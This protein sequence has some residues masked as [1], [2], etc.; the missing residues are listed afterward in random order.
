MASFKY[1]T[2]VLIVTYGLIKL[3][4]V[5][6]IFQQNRYELRRLKNWLIDQ[7]KNS[8]SLFSGPLLLLVS[9]LILK[10]WFNSFSYLV[11]SL[12]L[13][14][15][16]YLAWQKDQKRHYIIPLKITARVKRQITVYL[17]LLV[18]ISFLFY[19]YDG[20]IYLAGLINWLPWFLMGLTGLLTWPLEKLFHILYQQKAVSILRNR[21]NLIKIG[22]TGSYGKTSTKNIVTEILS[23]KYYCLMTPAS[24]NTP[25][26]ITMTIRQQLTALHQIFV[27]EMGADKVGEIKQL[28]R[29]VEPQYGIVTS[30]GYQHLVTFKTLNNIIKEKMSLI[31]SLPATGVGILNR[32]NAYIAS[33]KLKNE[34]QIK[35]FG[36]NNP[37]VDYQATEI[38]YALTGSQFIVK[39]KTEGNFPFQSPLLGEHNVA[40]VLA[41]IALGRE[42]GLTWSVLQLAVSRLKQVKNRLELK[43]INNFTFIDNS[44]NSNPASAKESLRIL[45]Q[46]PARKF[47]IT[48]G[49]IDLGVRQAEENYHFGEQMLNQVDEVILVGEKQ[50][51]DIYAGLKASGFPLA[52]VR[53][54]PSTAEAFQVVF[55]QAQVEDIILIEND[56]PDAFNQ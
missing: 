11:A 1:L 38:S 52:Q 24:F 36:I 21:P 9:L 35:W 34:C 15:I 5:L 40:N 17:V 47:I 48:P 16:S 49:F 8:A 41:G 20:I 56:L 4:Y 30:I 55:Q 19:R 3:K 28:A 46:M 2:M 31:E 22:I 10:L 26:G 53:V 37:D 42:L 29:F 54:V 13:G 7:F 39:S 23:Q 50:T 32:D 33:Y 14:A 43:K 45:A 27:C 44:F 25:M 6:L 51:A 12:V 18:V